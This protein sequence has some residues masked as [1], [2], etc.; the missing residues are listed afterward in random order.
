MVQPRIGDGETV[1]MMVRM[2]A[3]LRDRIK[4]AA[5]KSGRS[6]NSE[7]LN[8]LEKAFPAPKE[9][10]E[11]VRVVLERV[12]DALRAEPFIDWRDCIAHFADQEGLPADRFDAIRDADWATIFYRFVNGRIATLA[13][14]MP[15]EDTIAAELAKVECLAGAAQIRQLAELNSVL[16][17]GQFEAVIDPDSSSPRL[18]GRAVVL[19]LKP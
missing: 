2:S 5:E 11:A 12:L 6:Q 10:A 14:E 15:L 3:A 13:T 16:A 1:G 7:I 18:S 4:A 19:R 9:N 17:S 8:A